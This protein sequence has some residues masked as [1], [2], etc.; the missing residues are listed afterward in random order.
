MM[1]STILRRPI[2]GKVFAHRISKQPVSSLS[3]VSVSFRRQLCTPIGLQNLRQTA[4]CIGGQQSQLLF[5][6]HSIRQPVRDSSSGGEKEDAYSAADENDATEEVVGESSSTLAD[7]NNDDQHEPVY[8]PWRHEST[9]PTRILDMDDFSG[10]PNNFRAR[11]LRRLIACRELNLTPLNA[12]PLP[13]GFSQEWEEDLANNFA[14]AFKLSLEELLKSVFRGQVTINRDMDGNGDI[15]INSAVK[16]EEEAAEDADASYLNKMMDE[17]LIAKYQ[18]VDPKNLHL[19]L[20]IRTIEAK[21]QHIFAVP[22]LSREIVKNKPHLKGGYQNI[23]KAFAEKKSYNEVKTM[24]VDIAHDMLPLVCVFP[25]FHLSR[26]L[27]SLANC[28]ASSIKNHAS[29][30]FDLAKEIGDDDA[31]TRTVCCDATI[32]CSEFFQV[33]D[34]SSGLVVQGIEDGCDEE[35]VVHTVRFEVVTERSDDGVGRKVGS[36]TIIDIDDLLEGNVFH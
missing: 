17:N 18:S 24:Y 9:P 35:E 20:S 2:A 23:E 36:W 26:F 11:F 14:V 5:D 6:R 32:V 3:T 34:A 19:K 7:Q 27:A 1:A 16:N 15:S 10:M 25:V 29:R 33:K 12:V 13:F 22:L 28:Y 31:Y 4:V 8:F 30:T 21:L